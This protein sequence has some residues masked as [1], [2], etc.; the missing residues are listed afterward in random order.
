MSDDLLS[1]FDD[2]ENSDLDNAENIVN[3]IMGSGAELT[4]EHTPPKDKVNVEELEGDK[5]DDYVVEKS[6]HVIESVMGV[7]EEMSHNPD[8]FVYDA[9]ALEGFNG[10]INAATSAINSL[11]KVKLE[12]DKLTQQK[13]LKEKDI[14][15]KEKIAFDKNE[16]NNKQTIELSREEFIALMTKKNDDT[17]NN[18]NKSINDKGVIDV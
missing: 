14:T 11:N 6:A 16:N 4:K 2:L 18:N 1:E 5:L 17:D 8:A 12:R 15:S 7:V 10:L 3:M 13:E 9:K